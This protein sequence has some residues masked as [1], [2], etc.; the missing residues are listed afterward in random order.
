MR[1][2]L[3]RAKKLGTNEWVYGHYYH[4]AG[5]EGEGEKVQLHNQHFIVEQ[6]KYHEIKH[7]QIDPNTL[8]Q[9]VIDKY[10]ATVFEDDIIKFVKTHNKKSYI[11]R[12]EYC[13]GV[14]A[15]MLTSN[16]IWCSAE[17]GIGISDL[18]VIGNIYD[19]PELLQELEEDKS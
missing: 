5:M 16:K 15:F 6:T 9:L 18:E 14:A 8:G 2:I 11:G 17:F 3:F 4:K 10:G 13:S 1:R 12:V 19:N 7:T